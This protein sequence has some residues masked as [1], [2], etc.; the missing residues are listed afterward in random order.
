ME[1]YMMKKKIGKFSEWKEHHLVKF[2]KLRFK[3]IVKKH[4]KKVVKAYVFR[5]LKEHWERIFRYCAPYQFAKFKPTITRELNNNCGAYF[6]ENL[7]RVTHATTVDIKI[8]IEVARELLQGPWQDVL[9][10]LS[11]L[12]THFTGARNCEIGNLRWED[13]GKSKNEVGKFWVWFVRTSKMNKIPRNEQL[14]YQRHPTKRLFESAFL[15]YWRVSGKPTSGKIFPQDWFTTK[16]INY[17]LES[18]CKRLNVKPKLTCHS[19]RSWA[20]QQ[21][22]LSG[23][24]ITTI[25]TFMRWSVNSKMLYTYRNTAIE[26]TRKGGA[27]ILQIPKS[28]WEW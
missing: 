7:S 17:R 8:V 18:A 28:D 11:L 5:N 9:A 3:H 14:T 15:N 26:E 12:F 16:N 20:A 25:N 1:K 6:N 19:G 21:L 10:G 24:D 27:H 4:G 22:A 2:V 13:W 23:T